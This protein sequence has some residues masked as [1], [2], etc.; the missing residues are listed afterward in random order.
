[1]ALAVLEHPLLQVGEV[2]R[3][4]KRP[5]WVRLDRIDLRNHIAWHAVEDA[6]QSEA[7]VLEISQASHDTP[8]THIETRPGWK[9][10]AIHCPAVNFI[11]AVF[12]YSHTIG[13]GTSGKVFH[14]TVLEKLN[15]SSADTPVQLNG[16]ILEVPLVA[17]FTP[18]SEELLKL[19]LTPDFILGEFFKLFRPQ[20]FAPA[21]RSCDSWAPIRLGPLNSRIRIVRVEDET[22]QVCLKACRQHGT[23]LTGL[24]HALALASLVARTTDGDDDTTKGGVQ[25]GTPMSMR[26]FTRRPGL[27]AERTVMNC[28]TYCFHRAEAAEVAKLRA[29]AGGKAADGGEREAT[30]WAVAARVREDLVRQLDRG[31]K[32]EISGMLRFVPDHRPLLAGHGRKPRQNSLECSNLGV[33]DGGAGAASKEASAEPGP[34]TIDQALFSQSTCSSGPAISINPIAVKGKGLSISF[35][36]QGEVVSDAVAEG[37]AADTEA[38]LKQLGREGHL[39]LSSKC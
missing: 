28:V 32:N 26:R 11:E 19:K 38:W 18:T 39:S 22:L 21:I 31:T 29:P 4:S 7:L 24:I 17:N 8:F 30:V 1:M 10:N 3:E 33:M 37:V 5:S 35:C 15:G 2:G 36:W 34:W 13:D 6:S 16:H 27:D 14:L 12:T 23:T 20:R 9:I 25:S